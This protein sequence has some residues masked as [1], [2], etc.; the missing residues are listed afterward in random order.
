MKKAL[1]SAFIMLLGTGTF[2]QLCPDHGWKIEPYPD[3]SGC[4]I[5]FTML[6]S[7]PEFP[8]V[9]WFVEANGELYEY[10][11]HVDGTFEVCYNVAGSYNVIPT[12]VD[13]D[14]KT[15]C[16]NNWTVTATVDCA[17]KFNFC[18]SSNDAEASMQ[19]FEEL[20]GIKVVDKD[21]VE[22]P[23]ILFDPALDITSNYATILAAFIEVFVNEEKLDEDA[24][25]E[26]GT[27]CFKG[28]YPQPG[29][30]VFGQYT[31]VSFYGF[32]DDGNS[33]EVFFESSCDPERSS[34]ENGT[35]NSSTVPDGLAVNS[36]M[37]DAITV[38]NPAD[39]IVAITVL[40]PNNS[41]DAAQL[42]LVIFDINGREVYRGNT[43]TGVQKVIDVSRFE[44]GLYIYEVR[45]GET[46]LLKE[47]LL[48]K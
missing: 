15:L 28:D 31:S 13:A 38:P 46:V 11:E 8:W 41:S 25:G 4:C 7:T 36:N 27:N 14:N 5:I 10:D 26:G 16:Q 39:N 33:I 3:P 17:C 22:T 6:E 40:D 19:A 21:G 47:K 12:Y 34:I 45:D 20:I 24:V 48:V 30:S 35:D 29:F 2:A 9:Y 42:D 44:S 1:I 32:D 18:W 23:Y 37:F 43:T